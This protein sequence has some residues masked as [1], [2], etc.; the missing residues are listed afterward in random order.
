M[1]QETPRTDKERLEQVRSAGVH[2]A[3]ASAPLVDGDP[4]LA[5]TALVLAAGHLAAITKFPYDALVKLI[6]EHYEFVMLQELEKELGQH[7]E[8]MMAKSQKVI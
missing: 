8:A 1:G 3:M 7:G 4:H 5:M 2:L 6:S